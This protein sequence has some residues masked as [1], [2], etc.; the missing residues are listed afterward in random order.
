MPCLHDS[1]AGIDQTNVINADNF[2]DGNKFDDIKPP[3]AIFY[4]GDIGLGL[5]K[6]IRKALLCQACVLSGF[7]QLFEQFI[8]IISAYRT[9][10]HKFL[11]NGAYSLNPIWDYPKLE[12][13]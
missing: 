3:F 5:A 4:F 7:D 13:Y 2:G 1:Q 10:K 6:F 11:K 8:V 9:H 12:Y